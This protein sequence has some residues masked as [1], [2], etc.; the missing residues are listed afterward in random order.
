MGRSF[1]GCHAG[2][3]KTPQM[4]R[5]W[6]QDALVTVADVTECQL[7]MHNFGE[8]YN[9]QVEKCPSIVLEPDTEGG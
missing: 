2:G 8:F 6:K 3:W 9:N 7:Y 4:R 1:F 5:N